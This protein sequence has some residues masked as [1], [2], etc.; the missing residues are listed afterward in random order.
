M[1]AQCSPVGLSPLWGWGR[2]WSSL[3]AFGE[4]R[5]K[6]EVSTPLLCYRA[7]RVWNAG[8]LTV[9]AQRRASIFRFHSA[10]Q[11]KSFGIGA[12]AEMPDVLPGVWFESL[13]SV[14]NISAD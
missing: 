9:G 10:R 7:E 2:K 1:L 4:K 5:R 12:D 11:G 13:A 6:A 8:V 14:I 3:L